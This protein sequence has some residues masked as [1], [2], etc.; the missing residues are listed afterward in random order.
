[1][2]ALRRKDRLRKALIIVLALFRLEDVLPGQRELPW[3][4]VD[5]AVI[6]LAGY[7][8]TSAL[9]RRAAP[10]VRRREPVEMCPACH[11]D[12]REH[13]VDGPPARSASTSSTT[14]IPTL[15]RRR[16]EPDRRPAPRPAPDADAGDGKPGVR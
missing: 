11:H 8:V 13:V 10:L 3:V 12:W 7:F 4:L 2:E 1:M 14:K 9:A 5:V 6:V 16:A 15:L